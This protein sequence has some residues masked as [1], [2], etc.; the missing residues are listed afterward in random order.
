MR[1]GTP[2]NFTS[3][4]YLAPSVEANTMKRLAFRISAVIL[5]LVVLA[6]WT[7]NGHVWS[8]LRECY[9]R[10]YENAQVDDLRFKDFRVISAS[11]DPRPW[12][13][14]PLYTETIPPSVLDSTEI[15]RTVALAVVQRDSLVLDW[16]SDRIP[17][18]DTMRTN[19]FSMAKT[20]TALA[21]GAAVQQG[22]ISV[23]DPVSR[24]LPRFGEGP[25]ADLTVHQVL[26]MRSGIPF[27]ENYRNPIGF[28]ARSTYGRDIL[29]RTAGYTVEGDAGVPWLYQ[30]GNTLILHEI[31][32][33]VI[34]EPLGTW[35]AEQI[36][37][38]VGAGEDAAWAVDNR[39]QERNYCCF[40]SRATEYARLGKLL[41]DS[42]R[43]GS[44]QIV[45]RNF[46]SDLMS[47]VGLLPDG[48]DI[49]HYGYQVW[50]GTH[51]GHA[52]SGMLGLHGQYIVAIPDLDLVVVRT[53]FRQPKGKRRGI[54]EHVYHTV[55]LALD[56]VGSP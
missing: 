44:K 7:D 29:Q 38:P 54:D 22:L 40:Y 45:D 24:Y 41:L 39:G 28:M 52:F 10:G 21:I 26:Q 9:L 43:V 17:G 5:G 56:L 19:A 47:P 50:L 20:F 42:G 32:L 46:M 3:C 4:P 55:G 16:T 33:A 25:G 2:S 37:K 27:G 15:F 12:P 49:S 48:T 51:K 13:R 53:G 35:F 30:G 23:Q 1:P 14:H 34:E 36:W 8:G 31:L 18:A 11:D 6:E